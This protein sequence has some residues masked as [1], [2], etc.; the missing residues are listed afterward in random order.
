LKFWNDPR[1][2]LHPFIFTILF[3][4]C[5]LLVTCAPPDDPLDR[6]NVISDKV[7]QILQ[8]SSADSKSLKGNVEQYFKLK[9]ED[10]TVA[11]QQIMI[12]I[13]QINNEESRIKFVSRF[14]SYFG[15]VR[16]LE[17]LYHLSIID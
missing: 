2:G 10:I 17:A 12:E 1:P 11:Q 7:I 4:F 15:R 9:K 13:S 5:L 16:D 8:K 14:M 3:L 6:V